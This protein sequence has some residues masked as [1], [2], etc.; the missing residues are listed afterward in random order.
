[1]D[2]GEVAFFDPRE[3]DFDCKVE[4]FDETRSEPDDEQYRGGAK[5]TTFDSVAKLSQP[6][7][8]IVGPGSND[9]QGDVV[10]ILQRL[11]DKNELL[12]HDAC[13]STASLPA[14]LHGLG[15]EPVK[16]AAPHHQ[17][18]SSPSSS[19]LSLLPPAP[20]CDKV[21]GISSS[22]SV[23]E[24]AD[25]APSLVSLLP[26]AELRGPIA[27][28]AHHEGGY[29]I[30]LFQDEHDKSLIDM[31]T[32][33]ICHEVARDAVSLT[34]A[35]GHVFC[36]CCMNRYLQAQ[37][38]RANDVEEVK[39]RCTCGTGLKTENV[40]PALALRRAIAH[41][42]ATCGACHEAFSSVASY[43]AHQCS[44]HGPLLKMKRPHRRY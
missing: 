3:D 7:L 43:E 14:K 15:C 42:H 4:D 2:E 31:A 21:A 5:A 24:G 23:I 32:C 33:G 34:N 44:G 20:R 1:M 22:P 6:K 28:L 36:A 25:T 39:L 19:L 30:S 40:R 27:A 11:R 10:R 29:D 35:C 8:D 13:S 9:T 38:Q 18:T 37:Y 17:P 12:L 26:P 41:M 16:T